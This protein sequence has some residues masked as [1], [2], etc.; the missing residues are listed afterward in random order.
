MQYSDYS[1][2][3]EYVRSQVV[4]GD[5]ISVTSA[6]EEDPRLWGG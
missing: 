3:V 2:K 1:K 6:M 5:G 4:R